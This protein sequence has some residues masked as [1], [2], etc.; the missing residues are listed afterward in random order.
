MTE[1]MRPDEAFSRA[2]GGRSDRG[3]RVE[4]CREPVA[5]IG[6]GCRFPGGVAHPE[7]YW[8]MLCDGI[9]AIREV[10]ANRWNVDAYYDPKPG[11]PGKTNTRCGGFLEE[12]DRFDAEFFGIS[13]REAIRMDPQQ[14]LSLEVVWEAL[15]DAGITSDDIR[16]SATGVFFGVSSVD[17]IVLSAQ[18]DLPVEPYF[19]TGSAHSILT[20]RISY[21]LDL[22]GPS[23][24]VDTAC[25]SSLVAV[26][27]ACR[28]LWDGDCELALAG[29]VNALVEPEMGVAFAMGGFLAGDGRCKTFDASA[30]GYGRGE[31]CGVVVLKRLSDAVRDQDRIWAV[32]RGAAVNQ[33]GRSAGITAPKAS[34]Q[35]QVVRRALERAG[36][37]PEE[38]GYVEAHGTGTPLGDPIE[39][40]ALSESIGRPRRDG[41]RCALGTAKTNIG[42]LE[43]AA[44]I[45]GLIKAALV[46]HHGAVPPNLHFKQ[47]NPEISFEG[48]P[49]FVPTEVTEWPGR[50]LR[51]IAG[52]SS[53][54][55]SGTNAHVVLEEPP[56][57]A[58]GAYADADV[59]SGPK[60]L[61]V[62]A[63]S[64]EALRL[65]AG[66]YREFLGNGSGPE[67]ASLDQVC[68]AASLRRT[69]HPH[70]IAVVGRNRSELAER[71]DALAENE[72]GSGARAG[73]ASPGR[74]RK[75]AFVYSGQGTQ[76]PRMGLG[77]A[78]EEPVVRR[79]L[80]RCDE[81]F[82]RDGSWSLLKELEA[83]SPSSRLDDTEVAQPAI[84][85][86]QVALTELWRSWGIEP[87]A[88][89]G[90][91]IG[92]VAAAWA[93]GAIGLEDAAHLVL[94]RARLMQPATGQGRMAWVQMAEAEVS[95]YLTPYRGR[96]GIAAI[97]EPGSVV[98]SGETAAIEAFVASLESRG[99][100]HR[101]LPVNYAFHSP[102]MGPFAREL[103]RELQGLNPHGTSRLLASTVTGAVEDG[104]NL[105]AAYWARNLREPVKFAS[106]M[107]ELVR[108]GHDTFV[109]ISSHPTLGLSIRT[110][111]D[112]LGVRGSLVVGSLKRG[113]DEEESFL[114]A[115]ASL[116]VAGCGPDWRRRM[117][118]GA[119]AVA[120]PR[121]PWQPRRFWHDMVEGA[122]KPRESRRRVAQA[123]GSASPA[124]PFLERV[125]TTATDAAATFWETRIS[126]SLFP[127]LGDHRVNG[128]AV[129][130][131]AAYAEAALAACEE[132][133]G[134]GDH[135]LE[136]VRFERPLILSDSEERD[137]QIALRR[138]L[139]DRASVEIFSRA[140]GATS[141]IRHMTGSARVGETSDLR[142]P[143]QS[144]DLE[145]A[146]NRCKG[147]VAPE[148]FY[149]AA[150]ERGL[151]YGAA[152]RGIEELWGGD[153]EA[154]GRVALSEDAERG[155]SPY[156]VH[157]A[158]LDSVFQVVG[159]AL[160]TLEGTAAD[161]TYLPVGWAR[162]S[163]RGRPT[164]RLWVHAAVTSLDESGRS[165]RVTATLSAVDATGQVRIEVDAMELQRLSEERR[166]EI[167]GWLHRVTWV[168]T[169]ARPVRESGVSAEGKRWLILSDHSGVGAGLVEALEAKGRR[170]VVAYAG[171]GDEALGESRYAIAPEEPEGFRR[172][173]SS[174]A[175]GSEEPWEGVV[176][177]W[178]VDGCD[179]DALAPTPLALAQQRGCTSV[180]HLLQSLVTAGWATPPRLWL[181][182]RGAQ[183]VDGTGL[184]PAVAQAPLWGLARV[185]A[186]EHPELR[187]TRIDLDPHAADGEVKGLVSELLAPDGE[188]EVAFRQGGR[189]ASRL[190][191]DAR[192][193]SGEEDEAIDR[194]PAGEKSF[195][196]EIAT[197]GT[198]EALR[199]REIPRP[200]VASGEVAIRVRAAALNFK[201]VLLA[202][203]VVPSPI[204]GVVPLG[205]ECAGTVTAVGPGVTDVAPGDE[206]VCV[207]PFSFGRYVKTRA[208]Y[209]APKPE[210]L[211]MDEAAASPLVFMTALY[212]LEKIGRLAA[213]ERVLIHAGAGGVGLAAI[214]LAR[215]AGA[216]VLATAGSDEKRRYL[217]ER[218]NVT[219]VMDSRS[220]EFASQVLE[221][222]SGR[223]V[224]VVL[225]SLSGEAIRKNLEV[226]APYGRFL[227]IG[228]RDIY[229]NSRIGLLPF[230]KNLTYSAI[231]LARLSMERPGVFSE[232]L[233]EVMDRLA[234]GSLQPLPTTCFP[235]SRAEEAFRH[236]AQARQIGKI[237]LSLEEDDVLIEP[238]REAIGGLRADR[239]YLITGGLGGLGLSLA[240]WMVDEGARHIVLLGRS[241]PSAEAR[242]A[243]DTLKELGANV[244]VA[245]AD[246]ADAAQ[247]A[248]AID[249]AER[250]LP[251][252]AG[253]VHAAG[254]LDDGILLQQDAARFERVSAPK[255]FGA[256]NLHTLTAAKPLDFFAA[257]SSAASL[258]GSPGQGNYA[259]AN[260]FLDALAHFRRAQGLPALTINWGPWAEIGMAAADAKRGKR[261]EQAGILPI[262]PALG[263]RAFGRLLFSK[264]A[265]VGVLRV[266]AA[267]WIETFPAAAESLFWGDL[268]RKGHDGTAPRVARETRALKELRALSSRQARE[269]FLGEYLQGEVARA[270]NIDPTEIDPRAAFA[271]MGFD[272]LI[273]VE[274]KNR[275]EGS[276]GITL[277]ATALFGHPTLA[278][279]IPFI[280]SRLGAELG[281]EGPDSERVPDAG[282]RERDLEEAGELSEEKAAELLQVELDD[283]AQAQ[284]W[285]ARE[286]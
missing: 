163:V 20:G 21:L 106:A 81:L 266:D 222:T 241:V 268:V 11:T 247:L 4:T 115:V 263:W 157:P 123:D 71:L 171:S 276:L 198:L 281:E 28:S 70:R 3:N 178:S 197:P 105:G 65:L 159:S 226:L 9:D 149:E 210:C 183:V 187:C 148:R 261:L 49:F 224:D 68:R 18:E 235:I 33:D 95:P 164:G 244:R 97:N 223:G 146:R 174:V 127:F 277:S 52:V 43:A 143:A 107:A 141:W 165:D 116:Y 46:V 203:G 59:A 204:P 200:E 272:S 150:R 83:E 120:L 66:R 196:L 256:W 262:P 84:F 139:R 98:V 69:H 27:L 242:E 240:R 110:G 218:W 232:L 212:A 162:L 140:A 172:V 133:F 285:E 8:R 243:L 76:W 41:G 207:A 63:R 155:I 137:I 129:F 32:I 79:V 180:L 104:K 160:E 134:P 254:V 36:V 199:L 209:V 190:V 39:I 7:S 114:D 201:D 96:V 258:V 138:E 179:A 260:A 202:M 205:G 282:C 44:G 26:D 136:Q 64:A 29:G 113:R 135:D 238:R 193:E 255:I 259:A 14:R 265:Q 128:T 35:V 249:S 161:G 6:I 189:F 108:A 175:Q 237:V 253:V 57:E 109:E 182:T 206:V 173:T 152:F 78:A 153:R 19:A 227:E 144:S 186:L 67:G 24:P 192:V 125:V 101:W 248:A 91:S 62:S 126:E 99:I 267:R 80:E 103:E 5:I 236:M 211:S 90:H 51:R 229:E 56:R 264:V 188:T 131:A 34:S 47:L 145:G 75:V 278:S 50:A 217:R 53:F 118:C 38:V 77:L 170:C 216:E 87:T 176:H 225:N 119:R 40:E 25:S 271:D 112:Q 154:V 31:G 2:A 169:A 23:V 286:G 208:E 121:Y 100:G 132:A 214:Q 60:L 89:V 1:I 61:P 250:A 279:L 94:H 73:V 48:T 220:L 233:R 167:D 231:D 102:Q 195:R 284:G 130:P 194:V 30:D 42:H 191:R 10:P 156:R 88:V 280:V 22:I 275:L 251:P 166:D 37:E 45:A 181:V 213:G 58:G 168:R 122:R 16:G 15:E 177:L 86:I 55:F 252:L 184:A 215:A 72:Q 274:F 257:F 228:I 245:A 92:E 234:R 82:R 158:L 270:L 13:R 273:A 147:S 239:T 185:I 17:Y 246:V 12:V 124:H 74:K 142:S 230:Q 219:R 283:V 269:A 151:E 117:P 221:A 54:G 111:L 85:A 93:A